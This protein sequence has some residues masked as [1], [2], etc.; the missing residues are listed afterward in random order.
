MGNH[1]GGGGGGGGVLSQNTG[2]LVVLVISGNGFLSSQEHT[3]TWISAKLFE[4]ASL[5]TNFTEI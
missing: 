1:G 3:I 5:E 4:I 2:V